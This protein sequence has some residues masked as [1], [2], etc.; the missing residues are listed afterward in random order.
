MS[1]WQ[2]AMLEVADRLTPEALTTLCE[3][4]QEVGH[5]LETEEVGSLLAPAVAPPLRESVRHLLCEWRTAF[6]RRHWSELAAALGGAHLALGRARDALRLELVW[7]G[8]DPRPR[9][10]RLTE[11]VLFELVRAAQEQ[12]L[13][14]SYSVSRMHDLGAELEAAAQRGVAVTLILEGWDGPDQAEPRLKEFGNDPRGYARVLTWPPEA[15]Q[16]Q[17]AP[18]YAR[19]HAKCAVADT[20]EA[21]VTSANLSQA[22]HRTSMELGIRVVGGELPGQILAHFRGLETAGHLRE[23]KA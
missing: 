11:P 21:L 1:A 20:K 13:L 18:V 8:P 19:L 2:E 4:L 17:G 23:W 14:V 12:L 15:R 5:W 6:P 3:G 22:A 9:R 10:L 7:T 16:V